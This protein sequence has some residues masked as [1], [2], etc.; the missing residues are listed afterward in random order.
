VKQYLGDALTVK[1]GP[2][3]NKEENHMKK[4]RFKGQDISRE[5]VLEAMSRFAA[6]ERAR[7]PGKRW[8]T[9]AIKHEDR[10]YPPKETIRLVVG[11][12]AVGSG[13]EP[14]NSRFRELGFEIVTLTERQQEIP[15]DPEEDAVETSICLERDLEDNLSA[16][17]SQLEAGLV[18]FKKE[19]FSSRQL[20]TKAVGII[21]LVATD[22]AGRTVVIELKAGEASD[23]VC[24]QV[25]RYMGW[26]QENLANDAGVRGI[27]V[28]N[29]FT[30]G[31]RYAAKVVPNLVLKRY[32]V[33]F[34]FFEA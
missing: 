3:T 34:R 12:R 18:A 1:R 19:G 25:Q 7:F 22:R 10:L 32:T 31:A 14:I 27:I 5:D 24:G 30:E 11:S 9:Y 15:E 16:N 21:D 17:L 33:S 23:R 6:E 20:D 13:G 26:I 4:T 2:G 8:K 29:S 28:A